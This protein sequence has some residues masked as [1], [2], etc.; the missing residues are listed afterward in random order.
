MLGCMVGSSDER[1][2]R[3]ALALARRGMGSTHPNP[4]VG[5]VIVKEG[6]VIAEGWHVQP[7]AP[8]AEA[9]A[10]ARAGEAARGAVLY[11][12]LEP[13]AAHGRTPPCTEAIIRAGI[14]R[15]VIGC[16]DP[17]PKM[18]GGARILEQAGVQ[19][20]LGVCEREAR[21]LNRPFFSWVKRR[22]PWVLVKAALSLDGRLA[23]ATGESQ[24]ITGEQARRHAHRLR[25]E[26]DAI[27]VGAGTLLADNPRLTVRGASRRTPPPLRV[28]VARTAPPFRGHHA[29]ADAQAPSRLY[30]QQASPEDRAWR[31]AGVEVIEACNLAEM[32]RHLAVEGRLAVMVEGGGGLIGE[33]LRARLADEMA[34]FYAPI[35]I[36]GDG[37]PLWRGAGVVHLGAAPRLTEVQRRTLGSDLLVRGLVVYPD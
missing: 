16:L 21:A 8:H 22:R 13:C 32:F 4:R 37:V 26:Q 10:L 31:A 11:V 20:R 24:W 23:T 6:Q 17:N 1:W 27:V 33:I 30:V 34:L 12:N 35:L 19:I 18:A 15:V 3:R 29:I 25:A 36:G 5:C 14:R 2:M 9:M 7:G 28:V